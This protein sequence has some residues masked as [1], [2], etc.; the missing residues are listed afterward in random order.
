MSQMFDYRRVNS[1]HS[2]TSALSFAEFSAILKAIKE[3]PPTCEGVRLIS[4]A[5]KWIA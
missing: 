2:K 4:K 3:E 5:S 1:L